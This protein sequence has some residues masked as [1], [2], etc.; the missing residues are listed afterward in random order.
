MI[1]RVYTRLHI[2][3]IQLSQLLSCRLLL[4]FLFDK[5]GMSF[6]RTKTEGF[7]LYFWWKNVQLQQHVT[8]GTNIEQNMESHTLKFYT[9]R[10]FSC[11]FGCY[12]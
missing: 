5:L 3:K 1:Y 10:E 9:L 11:F 2:D 6:F 7:F 8:S 4:T 12:A